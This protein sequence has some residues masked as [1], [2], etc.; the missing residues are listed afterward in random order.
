MCLPQQR[1]VVGPLP[2]EFGESA[3]APA[4]G[5]GEAIWQTEI[6]DDFSGNDYTDSIE[7]ALVWADHIHRVIV[8]AGGSAWHWW[9]IYPPAADTGVSNQTLVTSRAGL[10]ERG[11]PVGDGLPHVLK[12]GYAIGQFARFVRPGFRRVVVD[13]EPAPGLKLSAFAGA[14]RLVIVAIHGGDG[15]QLLRIGGL[16]VGAERA[17]AWMTTAEQNLVPQGHLPGIEGMLDAVLPPR[18]VV[19]FVFD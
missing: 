5:H 7:D 15:E 6:S 18:S 1:L 12:R 11:D 14:D 19:T 16:P 8:D 4:G 10:V 13:P 17:A 3:R 2:V 9:W